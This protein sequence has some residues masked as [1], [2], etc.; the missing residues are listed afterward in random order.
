MQQQL[1][2]SNAFHELRKS[3]K[4]LYD[5]REASNIAHWVMEDLT[6]WSKAQRLVK[7]DEL[8]PQE[9]QLKLKELS[10]QLGSGM[11][12][13]HILG[14]GWFLGLKYKV[15][16]HVLIPRP[17]TE[18]LVEWVIGEVKTQDKSCRVLDIGTGSGCIAISLK[19]TIPDAEVHGW[20]ICQFALEVA[21]SN[22]DNLTAKVKFELH[23]IL[24]KL[25]WQDAPIFDVVVSN[26]PYIPIADA[27]AM[28]TNVLDFEPHTA[29][30]VPDNDPLLFYR[31]ILEFCQEHLTPNGLVFCELD[32]PHASACQ[33]LFK[34]FEYQDV[35]IRKDMQGLNRM[36]VA[37]KRD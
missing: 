8:L 15:N 23:D 2:I 22:A 36:L 3:V 28:H 7:K 21:K 32:A 5:D 6:G 34:S 1:T 31:A 12:V 29:L 37:R 4:H 14:F 27:T 13:Q 30:F 18:E 26:P 16:G 25:T 11:P 20:D 9:F 33:E 24:D 35:E 19:Y 17:E 10:V